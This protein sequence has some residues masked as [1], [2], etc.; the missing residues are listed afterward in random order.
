MLVV[1]YNPSSAI[2]YTGSRRRDPYCEKRCYNPRYATS[3]RFTMLFLTV[4]ES[5]CA[6]IP[7]PPK[8]KKKV[9]VPVHGQ[10]FMR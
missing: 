7:P 9:L 8:K 1:L 10:V 3:K 5:Y 4:I 6:N 2:Q